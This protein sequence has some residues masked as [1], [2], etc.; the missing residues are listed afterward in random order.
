[1]NN[2]RKMKK[3]KT[4]KKNKASPPPILHMR[5]SAVPMPP[6]TCT[7]SEHQSG[8]GEA[9]CPQFPTRKWLHWDLNTGL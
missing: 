8:T 4:Q 9:T 1:M 7:V 3:K 2:K 5:A 6:H